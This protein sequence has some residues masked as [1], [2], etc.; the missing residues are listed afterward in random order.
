MGWCGLTFLGAGPACSPA[1]ARTSLAPGVGPNPQPPRRTAAFGR[2]THRGGDIAVASLNTTSART[3]HPLGNQHQPQASTG[4]GRRDRALDRT[5]GRRPHQ[6]TSTPG[7]NGTWPARPVTG[8]HRGTSGQNRVESGC[9]DRGTGARALTSHL[10]SSLDRHHTSES[11]LPKTCSCYSI[12]RLMSEGDVGCNRDGAAGQVLHVLGLY[13]LQ[14]GVGR[15]LP[16]KHGGA[17][18]VASSYCTPCRQRLHTLWYLNHVG[19]RLVRNCSIMSR[20]GGW[21]RLLPRHR[22]S[23]SGVRDRH[24]LDE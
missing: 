4:N 13:G 18:A 7:V 9:T 10:P 24:D 6:P 1:P 22:C 2:P 8:R 14:H 23:D 3:Q 17:E 12:A 19:L 11:Q 21:T 16:C 5:E 20:E 15:K